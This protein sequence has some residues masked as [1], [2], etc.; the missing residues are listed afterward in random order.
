MK[1]SFFLLTH[2]F[3]FFSFF[4]K[5]FS[6]KLLNLFRFFSSPR[7]VFANATNYN[8]CVILLDVFNNMIQ[9]QFDGK[10]IYWFL[11]LTSNQIIFFYE[12]GNI[13]LIY[14]IVRQKELFEQLH[15][16]EFSDVPF[17][18][19][20][21]FFQNFFFFFFFQNLFFIINFLL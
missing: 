4:K 3:P 21:F 12:I 11:I 10:L 8:L 19:F 7:F 14:A 6:Y 16:L 18:F 1:I 20:F 15:D 13:R 2:F 5:K 9:Y 17:F